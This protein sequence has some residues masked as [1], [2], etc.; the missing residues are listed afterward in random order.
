MLLYRLS[1]VLDHRVSPGF[2]NPQGVNTLAM[3]HRGTALGA[4]P[5]DEHRY[6]EVGSGCASRN[7]RRQIFRTS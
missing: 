3:V 7:R 5:L 2:M 4:C 1:Q 6:F